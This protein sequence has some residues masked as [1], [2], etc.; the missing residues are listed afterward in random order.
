MILRQ[1]A[2]DLEDKD[3]IYICFCTNGNLFN[4]KHL[5]THTKTLEKMIIEL[6]FADAAALV[7]YSEAAL[8]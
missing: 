8:Q 2:E 4:L 7:A 3:C 5:Q 1:A 6:L